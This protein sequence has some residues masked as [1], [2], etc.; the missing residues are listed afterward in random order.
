M[1]TIM[2]ISKV[3][4]LSLTI[5]ACGTGL[6]DN[7]KKDNRSAEQVGISEDANPAIPVEE[8]DAGAEPG[9]LEQAQE[10]V[11]YDFNI[12]EVDSSFVQEKC[13]INDDDDDE[14][15]E[16]VRVNDNNVNENIPFETDGI[17]R[18]EGNQNQIQVQ[19]RAEE[20]LTSFCNYINGN[21]DLLTISIESNIKEIFIGAD[22]NGNEIA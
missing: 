20:E 12:V 19:L 9:E 18:V 14:G 5:T 2:Q 11:T 22:G 15:P 8:V 4:G 6:L 7:E 17:V 13:T 1:K 10:E 21:N 16:S 3:L